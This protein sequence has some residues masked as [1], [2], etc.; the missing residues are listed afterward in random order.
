MNTQCLAAS[1]EDK[2]SRLLL[3]II[4]FNYRIYLAQLQQDVV[5]IG[6]ILRPFSKAMES[7]DSMA[8]GIRFIQRLF[9]TDVSNIALKIGSIVEVCTVLA[10]RHGTNKWP[11]S[12]IYVQVPS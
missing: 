7:E 9:F 11:C 8:I 5:F 4:P 10:N 1:S 2:F 12:Q 3:P 6:T